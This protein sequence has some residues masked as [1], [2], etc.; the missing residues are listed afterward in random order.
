MSDE[1][2]GVCA[3]VPRNQHG[4]RPQVFG[5]GILV[6]SREIV[7]CAHVIDAALGN[8][9]LESPAPSFVNICFPFTEGYT[10]AEGTVDK[11]RWFP[12]G[13][14]EDGGPSDVAVIQLARDAPNSVEHALLRKPISGKAAKVYGFRG[15]IVDG[16]WKSHPDGEWAEGRVVGLQSGGRAQFDGLRATGARVEKGFS[17]GAVYDSER[18]C[19]VGMIAE[20]DRDIERMV[21]QFIDVPSLKRALAG[22]SST[23]EPSTK[24]G[25]AGP[26][27]VQ[28]LSIASATPKFAGKIREFLE[29]YLVNEEWSGTIIFGGRDRELKLLD[30]WLADETAPSRFVLAAPAGRGKSA[31]VVQW[32][33]R[34][35]LAGKLTDEKGG[36]H[37]AFV[38]ISMRFETNRPVTYY[39]AL[40]ARLAEIL[41]IDL[42]APASAGED[43]YRDKCRICLEAANR[44]EVPLLLIIDGIDESAGAS[45]N[46]KWFP[47]FEGSRIRLLVSGRLLAGD[48]DASGWIDRLGWTSGVLKRVHDLP[49]L[50]QQDVSDLLSATGVRPLRPDFIRRLLILSEGEPLLLKLYVEELLKRSDDASRLT[51]EELDSMKPGFAPY[52]GAWLA[53]QEEAWGTEVNRQTL[54]ACFAIFACAYGPLT[55]D[56]LEKL[57]NRLNGGTTVLRIETTLSPIRRFVIG[58]RRHSSAA[59]SGYVLSHPKFGDFLRDEYF[60]ASIIARARDAFGDWGRDVVVKLNHGLFREAPSYLLQYLVQHLLDAGASPSDFMTLVEEGWMRAWKAFEG[61]FRGFAEDVRKVDRALGEASERNGWRLGGRIRCQLVL[62][63]IRSVG[64]NMPRALIAECVEQRLL[65]HEEAIDIAKQKKEVNRADI[66]RGLLPS[67]PEV[68]LEEALHVAGTLTR[69]DYFQLAEAFVTRAESCS[70]GEQANIITATGIMVTKI[71][72]GR[73][74]AELLGRLIAASPAHIRSNILAMALTKA[75]A[76]E[77]PESPHFFYRSRKNCSGGLVAL[78]PALSGHREALE[79]ALQSAKAIPDTIC[80]LEAVANLCPFLSADRQAIILTEG[81]DLAKEYE[82]ELDIDRSAIDLDRSS[83][84][85]DESALAVLA[86]ALSGHPGLLPQSVSLAKTIEDPYRRAHALAALVT[87]LSGTEQSDAFVEAFAIAASEKR[88]YVRDDILPMLAEHRDMFAKLVDTVEDEVFLVRLIPHLVATGY[89]GVLERAVTRAKSIKNIEARDNAVFKL[90]KALSYRENTTELTQAIALALLIRDRSK[91]AQVI[92]DLFP[93]M[94][95]NQQVMVLAHDLETFIFET[96]H[97]RSL[98]TLAAL[99]QLLTAFPDL[100]DKTEAAVRTPLP[101]S[102][103]GSFE[104]ARTRRT[105]LGVIQYSEKQAVKLSPITSAFAI[106]ATVPALSMTRRPAVLAELFRIADE[107]SRAVDG[108]EMLAFLAQLLGADQRHEVITKLGEMMGSIRAEL[109]LDTEHDDLGL[110]NL[111]AALAVER[112]A[113][114][115]ALATFRGIGDELER[116]SFFASLS[117]LFPA[118]E[119][120]PILMDALAACREWDWATPRGRVRKSGLAA[121]APILGGHM[122]V[123]SDAIAIAKGIKNAESRAY[124]LAALVPVVT[125]GDQIDVFAEAIKAA[126]LSN[127]LP[128]III[129]L[130][131]AVA[132]RSTLLAQLG[133]A[134]KDITDPRA[135]I[136]LSRAQ[137]PRQKYMALRRAVD[138]VDPVEQYGT[139]INRAMNQIRILSLFP[140]DLGSIPGCAPIARIVRKKRREALKLLLTEVRS[141]PKGGS[142]ESSKQ[143]RANAML[144]WAE[145]APERERKPVLPELVLR[146]LEA[147]NDDFLASGLLTHLFRILPT[148]MHAEILRGELDSAQNPRSLLVK[149]ASALAEHPEVLI[150]YPELTKDLLNKTWTTLAGEER[151]RVLAALIRGVPPAAPDILFA[152]LEASRGEKAQFERMGILTTILAAATGAQGCEAIQRQASTEAL[153]IVQEIEDWLIFYRS[154]RELLTYLTVEFRPQALELLVQRLGYLPRGTALELLTLTLPTIE[155]CAGASGLREVQRAVNDVAKWFP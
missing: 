7:T 46:A 16:V 5:M 140:K 111:V 152:A 132:G 25:Q 13:R 12:S 138:N 103:T 78:A 141:G 90:I 71:T 67:L 61:G 79:E 94:S 43:H 60:S 113:L 50:G 121:L 149:F 74:C 11:E 26:D 100:V 119:R 123:H 10:C 129:S 62:S 59:R 122:L 91:R 2:S 29:E 48:S 106:A 83:P 31:L 54:Y 20:S 76:D 6:N 23:T 22:T 39:E 3:I 45:F 70:S 147:S 139:L 40:A 17:G 34:L 110:E 108:A 92:V 144:A 126:I 105:G 137:P 64:A 145:A 57:A 117:Q 150:E 153:S 148:H 58:S 88:G 125:D 35:Y 14:T 77:Q 115:G 143:D 99:A 102:M 85:H 95:A 33:R 142:F 42:D 97:R 130:A 49:A 109:G 80:R 38:P 63:S 155:R 66:L 75:K 36:W 27:L 72:S 151:A 73:G 98:S 127:V 19:V 24:S 89:P 112:P 32:I 44:Q 51:L 135:L 56:E 107:A 86:P 118:N 124:A 133:L 81:I 116:I 4:L 28:K 9:W 53:K 131:P 96:K 18:N 154:F 87:V 30:D 15:R 68:L 120:L 21:A 55:A 37:L 146:V 93:H 65:S 104:T 136:E 84:L 69:N 1:K 101:G 52:F 128:K 8:G 41:D 82:R 134:A 114:Q 47:R